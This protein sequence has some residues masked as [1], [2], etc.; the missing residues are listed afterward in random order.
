MF[1][2]AFL[3]IK[4]APALA[5]VDKDQPAYCPNE[6]SEFTLAETRAYSL[7]L[8]RW[9]RET[10]AT[11]RDVVFWACVNIDR[12]AREP[13]EHYFW[14][15]RKRYS[16][17][18]LK[19]GGSLYCRLVNGKASQIAKEFEAQFDDREMMAFLAS[20]PEQIRAIMT[21]VAISLNMRCGS[22]YRK[23]ILEPCQRFPAKLLKSRRKLL[24]A[25]C[26]R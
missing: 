22:A 10:L 19:E 15:S 5:I 14:F 18:Q 1:D 21:R 3:K 17:S 9:R 12:W 20:L 26:W 25:I 7:K 4:T 16:G 13:W 23:R 6:M 24:T 2:R 8:G 11:A